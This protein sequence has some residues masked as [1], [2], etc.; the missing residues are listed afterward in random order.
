MIL[1]EAIS[2]NGVEL[3]AHQTFALDP[4]KIVTTRDRDLLV[5]VEYGETF[6]RRRQPITYVLTT[7]RASILALITG[8]YATKEFL[9]VTVIGSN[10]EDFKPV[11]WVPYALDL[12]EKYIVDIRESY[13][14]VNNVKTACRRIEYV[15]GSFVP[16]VIYVSDKLL[17]LV[18]DTPAAVT[19]TTT[20]TG[21]P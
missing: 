4:E 12:Q 19:T 8:T 9:S 11:N 18:T 2:R 10:K 3:V 15:P 5:E 20:T 1:V 13:F 7:D 21:T 17:D 6:D 16:V 14:A